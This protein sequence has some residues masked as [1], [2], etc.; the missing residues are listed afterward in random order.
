MAFVDPLIVRNSN[1]FR[2]R[3][4]T[5]DEHMVVFVRR[6]TTWGQVKG[7]IWDT[8]RSRVQV[9]ETG[10]RTLLANLRRITEW[11]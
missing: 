3:W 6:P 11:I 4:R 7:D 5:S 2:L 9:V 10:A 8:L 1:R